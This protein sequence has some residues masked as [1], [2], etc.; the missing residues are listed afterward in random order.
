MEEYEKFWNQAHFNFHS[1]ASIHQRAI[2]GHN[3]PLALTRGS[4]HKSEINRYS[5][6]YKT[7]K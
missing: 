6:A 4:R 3:F 2:K 1:L 7:V 5:P